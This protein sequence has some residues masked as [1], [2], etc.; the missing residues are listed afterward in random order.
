MMG[1]VMDFQERQRHKQ[2]DF[3]RRV[4]QDL[5]LEKIEASI[6]QRFNDYLAQVPSSAQTARDMCAEYALEAFLLGSSMGR[7]GFYGEDTENVFQRSMLPFEAL[8]GD[9]FDFWLFWSASDPAAA[10]E[11]EEACDR[12]LYTWWQEGF[13]ASLRRWRMK[14]R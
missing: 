14:L 13:E 12:Y 6:R 9:F 1:I 2:M 3:E 8:H 11:L 10:T 4:L 5:S 7:F